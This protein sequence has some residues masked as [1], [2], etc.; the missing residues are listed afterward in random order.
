MAI[1]GTSARRVVGNPLTGILRELERDRRAVSGPTGGGS[2]TTSYAVAQFTDESG[3]LTV[4]FPTPFRAFPIV[5]VTVQSLFPTTAN[6]VTRSETQ[7]VIQ[8][9][10]TNDGSTAPRGLTTH[11]YAFESNGPAI[12][13]N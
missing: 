10:N 7:V 6:I 4:V 11:V 5:Q 1:R 12:G 13:P 8:V 2:V 3:R 9:Y